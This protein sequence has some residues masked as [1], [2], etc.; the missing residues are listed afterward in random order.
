MER[1]LYDYELK[2]TTWVYLSSLLTI[3]IFFKFSRFWS[4]RNLDLALLIGLSPG[5]LMV[6]H[7][8]DIR[9]WGYVW[10][11]VV[12]GL[13]LL[14]LVYDPRMVRRPLLEPNLSPG[15]LTFI[16][17]CLLVFLL[18]NVVIN[19]PTESD[20]EGV[21]KLDE[22]LS[23]AAAS[24]QDKS[25]MRHG[26]GYPWLH[27]VPSITTKAV[28]P[29]NPA[30][31]EEAGKFMIQAATARTMAILSHLAVVIGIVMIGVWHF[32]NIRT[33]VA[34]ATLY[35][36][37]PYTALMTGRVDHVLPAALLVW[38]IAAYRRPLVSGILLGLAAGAIYYPV[39]LLPLWVGFYW[40]GG[41]AR[42]AIGFAATL[43]VMVVPLVF[44]SA[45]LDQFVVQIKMMFGWPNFTAPIAEGFW[46]FHNST[47]P[48]RIP[49]LVA[50]LVTCGVFAIWPA[51]KNLGTLLSCSA[52]VML[53]AQFW[54]AGAGGIYQAWYLP[55]LLLT[56][57]RPNLE[58][59]V[60]MA[61]VGAGWF[62]RRRNGLRQ[63]A[64]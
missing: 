33:G 8:G 18:V 49:V 30:V 7:S 57:F 50:F 48:Y 25:L 28:S 55:L 43:A 45:N 39:F 14:R 42:F 59:R 12:S 52:A 27:W 1:L 13:L 20:L 63:Q 58:D 26:P 53:G 5:L 23:G 3:A 31:S 54:I 11:F 56:M 64:A 10:L 19:K 51:Q 17:G 9:Y 32:D 15:G 61:T 34:A 44:T 21:R 24:P 41:L 46:S 35:L 29:K 38:A 47:N 60:A 4:M 16:A 22:I 37:L 6:T 2:P 40:R 62:A 36:L